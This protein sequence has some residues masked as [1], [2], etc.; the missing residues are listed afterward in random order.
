MEG[1]AYLRDGKVHKEHQIRILAH[2]LD[3]KAYNLNFYM[4]K[5]T[6]D[7]PNNWA[8]HK[9][10][11]ELFNYCFPV[12]YRQWM[13]LKL[14]D[15][16]QKPNQTVAKYVFELQ[17]LFSMVGTMPEEMKV[18]KLWYSLRTQVQHAL[19]RDGLHPDSST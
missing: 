14:E 12:D 19:W 9:F 4:Q 7:D 16:S 11:T 1:E 10:F 18:V 6:S 2:H 3:G 5:V 8:L 13:R 15:F 17:E